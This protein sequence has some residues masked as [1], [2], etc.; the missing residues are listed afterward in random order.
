MIAELLFQRAPI[1][2][3]WPSLAELLTSDDPQATAAMRDNICF[4]PWRRYRKKVLEILPR[5]VD[6]ELRDTIALYLK[7]PT[8][9][10]VYWQDATEPAP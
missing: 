5:V 3:L 6:E 10:A 1:S 8:D 2:P 9:S 4:L 7:L